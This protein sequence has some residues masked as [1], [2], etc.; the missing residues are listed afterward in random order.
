MNQLF[1]LFVNYLKVFFIEVLIF[2]LPPFFSL[3]F[4]VLVSCYS[5]EKRFI[6]NEFKKNR[7]I[8]PKVNRLFSMFFILCS[9]K[10]YFSKAY[11]LATSAQLITLKKA[12]I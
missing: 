9:K 7:Q 2:F 6:D 11:L 4:V 1:S 10:D 5:I 8:N 3:T 12:S